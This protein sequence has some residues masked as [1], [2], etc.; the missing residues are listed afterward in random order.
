M[1]GRTIVATTVNVSRVGRF[2][3]CA[4]LVVVTVV[5]RSVV[6]TLECPSSICTARRFLEPR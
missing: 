3:R 1:T 5:F 4:Y 6:A 2:H